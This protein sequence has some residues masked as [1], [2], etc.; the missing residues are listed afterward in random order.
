MSLA[1]KASNRRYCAQMAAHPHERGSALVLAL[2]SAFLL[3]I[4][5]FEVAHTTRIEGFITF[6]IEDETKLE[7]SCRAGLEK[8][9]AVLRQDRQETEIDSQNDSWWTL[10]E[11][12]D[13]VEEDVGNDEFLY[14]EEP[15]YG[16]GDS[17]EKTVLYVRIFDEAA[18]FNIYLLLADDLDEQRKR[19]ERLANV[20]DL[21]REDTNFDL[22]YSEAREIAEDIESYL[23]RSPDRPYGN[24][25]L[26]KSKAPGTILTLSELLYVNAITPEILFDVIDDDREKIVPGLFRFLTIWSDMQ[27]NINTCE[28]PSLAGLFKPADTV[29]AER[30]YEYRTEV[31]EESDRNEDYGSDFGDQS[32]EEEGDDVT[33]GAPFTQVNELKEKIDGLTQDIYNE[34]SPYCTVQSSVFSVFVTAKRGLVRRTK[35]YV[36]RRSESGFRLLF[37]TLVDFPYLISNESLKQATEDAET[38]R[39]QRDSR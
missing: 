12:S 17:A 14:E 23:K 5:S 9:L 27:T 21:F 2:I 16:Y 33:G 37:E 28:L 34:I 39:E 26:P 36:V 19:R 18:K 6:N 29:L 38:S 10:I 22:G 30:I 1:P 24:A 4:V 32:D 25:P 11:D 3:L 13:L 7:V 20:I 35:M 8:A 31:Q 15:N